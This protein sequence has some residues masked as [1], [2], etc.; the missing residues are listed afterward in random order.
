MKILK[1]GRISD[2]VTML[3]TCKTCEAELEINPKDLTKDSSDSP[4]DSIT[5]FYECPCCYEAN[6]LSYN[7]LTPQFIKVLYG[8]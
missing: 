7:D 1:L 6:R 2:K 5:Y 4:M 8:S 3:V